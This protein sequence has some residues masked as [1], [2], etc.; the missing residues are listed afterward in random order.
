MPRPLTD[1]ERKEL[2]RAAE[3]AAVP[4]TE[5]HIFLC[6][7]ASK[8]KCCDHERALEAWDYLKGR[9]KE[10]GLSKRGAVARTKAGCLRMCEHGP[11]AVVYPEGAWYAHCDPPVIERI[12][13]EHLIEGRPVRELLFAAQP[14]APP[15]KERQRWASRVATAGGRQCT[16]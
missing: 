10:L 14:L 15:V 13:T 9:L 6:C 11:I 3:K 7:D 12:I 5:R 2:A 16:V 1:Q 4:A 8:S